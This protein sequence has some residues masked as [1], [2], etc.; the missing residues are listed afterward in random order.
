MKSMNKVQLIGWLGDEP[1]INTWRDGKLVA[2]MRLATDHYIV[3]PD[4]TT[5]QFTCWHT[6][7]LWNPEQIEFL[8]INLTRGSHVFVEGRIEY[9]QYRD[10]QGI[11]RMATEIMTNYLIDLDR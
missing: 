2:R 11:I 6:V 10:K 3:R 7:K 9:R 8:R 5:K 4:G 1:E